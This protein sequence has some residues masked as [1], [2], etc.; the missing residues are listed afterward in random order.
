[1]CIRDS[2]KAARQ[3]EG[4]DCWGAVLVGGETDTYEAIARTG[5][6]CVAIDFPDHTLPID[7]IMQ[8]NFGGGRLAA[9][10]LLAAGHERIAWFGAVST[11]SHALERFSGAR[12]AFT[13]RGLDIPQKYVFAEAPDEKTAREMLSRPDRP[14]AVLAMWVGQTLA[15]GRAARSLG[16]ELGRDLDMVGWCTEE[17]YSASIEREFGPGKAPPVVVW[18][19]EEMAKIA[20][21]RLL[22]HLREPNLKPLRVSV[23]MRLVA[24]ADQL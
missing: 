7:T 9:E 24:S 18:S 6:P 17:N 21:A 10:H 22:W 4:V 15:V 5:R 19:T 13:A 16:L 11:G 1:M 12:A 14:T 2:Q 23:P 20:L 8:D 3:L